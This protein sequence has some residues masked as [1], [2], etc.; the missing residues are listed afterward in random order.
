MADLDPGT[1]TGALALLGQKGV[2]YA[3]VIDLGSADG[4]FGVGLLANGIV[5]GAVP[6]NIDPNPIYE[7][8][9]RAVQDAFGGHY[10]IAAAS[11]QPG[12]AMMTTAIHPYWSSLRPADDPYW[13]RINRLSTGADLV[14]TVRLDDVVQELGC[15]P[16]FLLRLDI[17][18]GE[19]A[20]LRGARRV[21]AD[22]AVVVCEAD[23]EDFRAID[24]EL[25]AAGFDLFDLTEINRSASDGS[26]GWFYPIYL[27]RSL[28]H[29]RVRPFWRERDNA[30]VIQAQVRRRQSIL[31][32]YAD[33]LPKIK[34]AK[35]PAGP[36]R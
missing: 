24:A 14:K 27:S 30:A 18:G 22:V 4:T 20:A 5:A 15:R 7:A 26:L 23:V 3:T 36:S 29:L 33:I 34:A 32:W 25:G 8:S 9:L 16:P 11:D 31:A 19:V 2:T 28:G 13:T 12:E 21:L 10:L 6:L 35:A 1:M 17:Q